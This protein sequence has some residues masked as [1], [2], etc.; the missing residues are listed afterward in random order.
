MRGT[1]GDMRR[2]M[3]GVPLIKDEK[4][5]GAIILHRKQVPPFFEQQ[6]E[7]VRT[8]ADRSHRHRSTH[9]LFEAVQ[10]RTRELTRR[11]NTR[12]QRPMC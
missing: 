3:L 11:L 12:Q 6:I 2:T 5:I 1:V 9:R 7:L 4:V 10:A 8:F